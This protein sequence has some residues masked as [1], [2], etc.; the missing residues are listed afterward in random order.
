MENGYINSY[1]AIKGFG[2][3]RRQQGKDV[4][5]HYSNLNT[6]EELIGEGDK[7]SFNLE[8]SKKGLRAINIEKIS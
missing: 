3:I 1:D 7:V 2:F 6:Q 4:F 5:F 8:P